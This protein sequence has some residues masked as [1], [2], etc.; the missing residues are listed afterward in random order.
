MQIM[1]LIEFAGA[2]AGAV[3]CAPPPSSPPTSVVPT[4]TSA[5][6]TLLSTP[7]PLP[8]LATATLVTISP[9]IPS[10]FPLATFAQS[11]S[12]GKWTLSFKADGTYEVTEKGRV[13]VTGTFA[14]VDDR[15]KFHDVSGAGSCR[16]AQGD[17]TYR[18]AFEGTHL[19]LKGVS[20]SCVSRASKLSSSGWHIEP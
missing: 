17:G 7:T 2:L 5:P 9:T 12:D 18:W 16:T 1:R 11:D 15:I 14:V 13:I 19:T 20:D 6:T 8:A 3:A 10:N 4:A